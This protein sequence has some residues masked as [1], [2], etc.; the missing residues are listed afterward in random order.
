MDRLRNIGSPL[1]E[2][3]LQRVYGHYDQDGFATFTSWRGDKDLATNKRNLV[4]LK[5][6]VRK[7]GYGFIPLQGVWHET[8]APSPQSEPSIFIPSKRR[9]S[10]DLEDDKADLRKLA[11][12]LGIKYEQDA[13]VWSGGDKNVELIVTHKRTGQPIRKIWARWTKFDPKKLGDIYSRLVKAP[14]PEKVKKKQKTNIH[15]RGLV[16]TQRAWAFKESREF[17]GFFFEKPPISYAEA[18]MRRA[19]GES[20]FVSENLE[21]IEEWDSTFERLDEGRTFDY[22]VLLRPPSHGGVPDGWTNKRESRHFKHGV[23]SYPRPLRKADIKRF[24]LVPLDIK[25]PINIKKVLDAYDKYVMDEFS[26]RD[27]FSIKS[28]TRETILHYST[29]PGVDYQLSTVVGGKPTG[30]LDLNDFDDAVRELW[31]VLPKQ[32]KSRWVKKVLPFIA[33]GLDATVE[34]LDED[35]SEKDLVSYL[36]KR[37][38]VTVMD[39]VIGFGGQS[40][41]HRAALDRLVKKGRSANLW[42]CPRGLTV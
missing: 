13:V 3:T 26:S 19:T 38:T 30:H 4:E 2:A 12:K 37:K 20:V 27:V 6:M 32:E 41:A 11:I 28:G 35:W 10:D 21:C 29:R 33:E 17:L 15:R 39:L 8:G 14:K 40:S 7:A 5:R 42:S 24:S 31:S 1:T 34:T 25:D 23:I 9:D 16:K 36:K 22:G 18:L